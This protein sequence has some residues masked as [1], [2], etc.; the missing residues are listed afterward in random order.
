MRRPIRHR[1][2]E[3]PILDP[4]PTRPYVPDTPA[5]WHLGGRLLTTPRP[6]RRTHYHLIPHGLAFH[7]VL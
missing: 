4:D 7:C 5:L 3:F 1:M 6:A 2:D